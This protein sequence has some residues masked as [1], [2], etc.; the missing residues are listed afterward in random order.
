MSVKWNS[1]C[2]H[3]WEFIQVSVCVCIYIYIYIYVYVYIYIYISYHIYIYIISI[4]IYIYV[5]LSL[6][7]CVCTCVCASAC[8]SLPLSLS[9]CRCVLGGAWVGECAGACS[10]CGLLASYTFERGTG[11][12]VERFQRLC[13][14]GELYPGQVLAEDCYSIKDWSTGRG[15]MG[16]G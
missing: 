14:K 10:R 4:Y 15:L 11:P 13:S 9:L 16:R 6:S 2:Q 5:Y 12:N 8:V 1:A 3:S 7:L